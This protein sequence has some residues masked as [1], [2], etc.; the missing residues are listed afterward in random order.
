MREESAIYDPKTGE[1]I[2][3]RIIGDSI[4]VREPTEHELEILREM[5]SFE[6][7]FGRAAREKAEVARKANAPW[8]R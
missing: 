3:R 4:E 6:E 7:R 8:A 2:G 1:I 5:G